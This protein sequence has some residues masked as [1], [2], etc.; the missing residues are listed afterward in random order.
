MQLILNNYLE[1]DVLVAVS[2]Y[3]KDCIIDAAAQVDAALGTTYAEELTRRVAISYPPINAAPL[4]EMEFKLE[5]LATVWER[6]G[7]EEQQYVLFLSRLSEAKG[8]DDLIAGYLHSKV[9]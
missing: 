3:T 4:L 6:Y 2:D 5:A 8:V 1:H 9:R 7:V